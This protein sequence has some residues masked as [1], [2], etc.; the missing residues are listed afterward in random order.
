[1]DEIVQ[2]ES[3]TRLGTMLDAAS[4]VA[5]VTHTRPDGDAIGS[6]VALCTYL[7]SQKSKD[8]RIIIP[9]AIPDT[10]DF[11]LGRDAQGR[12][13]QYDVDTDAADT[14]L[15]GCDL[16]A[17]LDISGFD[18]AD[19]LQT[20]L[21][22]CSAT[23][24][25]IDHHLAPHVE[26]F[27]LCIS[28]T[29][30]SSASELLY[31]S[32][33]GLPGIDGDP[34]RIPMDA[35]R[36]LMVGMTTDTNNFANSVFPSTLEMASQM[37]TAGVDRDG[38]IA[39]I[40]NRYRENRFRMM[41]FV[42]KDRMTILPEGLAYVVLFREDLEAY[43]IREG[44]LEGVVNLPLGIDE[45][46]M[47]ILLKEDNGFFRVSIRSKRGTSANSMAR[48]FFNGGGHEQASGGRLFY[49]RDIA[50]RTLAPR[51]VEQ[52]SAT[53]FNGTCR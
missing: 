3:I 52:A 32:L 2:K 10:L 9:N 42:L 51:Y 14:W 53:F 11:V 49:P 5:I 33:L 43:D 13:L 7:V 36:A 18:R 40:Y 17:A 29:D 41:G 15:A 25:L 46:R 26:D 34:R 20:P 27:A 30:I 38:L 47:S 24:L 28:R 22:A 44:E 1:M 4:R 39:L 6:C 45:V 12:L 50:D 21:R 31:W 19:E 35:L 48:T 8:C 16:V 23:K 37:L